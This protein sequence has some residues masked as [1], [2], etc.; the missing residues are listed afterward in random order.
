MNLM[1]KKP[2]SLDTLFRFD[3]YTNRTED[4]PEISKLVNVNRNSSR[5]EI[6]LE[7]DRI[8]EIYNDTSLDITPLGKELY[9]KAIIILRKW[10]RNKSRQ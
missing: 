10:L 8:K 6:Q 5:E 2:F 9:V 7:L 3:P 1:S 4:L